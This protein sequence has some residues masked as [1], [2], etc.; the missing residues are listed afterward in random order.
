[1]QTGNVENFRMQQESTTLAMKLYQQLKRTRDFDTKD[2]LLKSAVSIAV[3]MDKFF[4]KRA[5]PESI[6][7]LYKALEFC[8]DLKAQLQIA[9]DDHVL[10]R[11]M[12]DVMIEKARQISAILYKLIHHKKLIMHPLYSPLH[13]AV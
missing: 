12:A 2:H 3:H 7:L 5:H 8:V 10:I 9:K 11:E 6:Q 1:M 4:E 13:Y